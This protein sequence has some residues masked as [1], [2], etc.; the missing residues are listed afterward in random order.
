M[1]MHAAHTQPMFYRKAELFW[2]SRALKQLPA[3]QSTGIQ[4]SN[5]MRQ[6]NNNDLYL[7]KYDRRRRDPGVTCLFPVLIESAV[8]HCSPMSSWP[9]TFFPAHDT[10]PH[11][12]SFFFSRTNF[13]FCFA[14]RDSEIT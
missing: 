11:I 9:S 14:Q 5:I 8:V 3:W 10:V 4:A 13:A 7:K 2:K 1:R 6:P 12:L